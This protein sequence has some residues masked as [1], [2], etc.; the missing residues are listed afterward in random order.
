MVFIYFCSNSNIDKKT[1]QVQ[2]LY[3]CSVWFLRWIL[4]CEETMTKL[5][6]RWNER[7]DDRVSWN[8]YLQ[9]LDEECCK[10]WGCKQWCRWRAKSSRWLCHFALWIATDV[11]EEC[12]ASIFRVQQSVK[13]WPARHGIIPEDLYLQQCLVGVWSSW[14]GCTFFLW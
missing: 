8:H 4:F 5:I 1:L 9:I 13:A 2:Q 6:T 3:V 14:P 10:I 12:A 11:L 7:N